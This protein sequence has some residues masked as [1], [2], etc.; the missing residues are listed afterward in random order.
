MKKILLLICCVLVLSCSGCSEYNSED[1]KHDKNTEICKKI[2]ERYKE[3]EHDEICTFE[4]DE[5]LEKHFQC[6]KDLYD[7]NLD[8]KIQDFCDDIDDGYFE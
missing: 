8:K 7:E 3:L 6:I 4:N 1:K 5:K 2:I